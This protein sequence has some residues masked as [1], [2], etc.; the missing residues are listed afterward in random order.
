ME[1]PAPLWNATEPTPPNRS[2][3]KAAPAATGCRT[4]SRRDPSRQAALPGA[5]LCRP[6]A[7]PGDQRCT[8]G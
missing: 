7:T 3:P 6:P 4:G 2:H 5:H 8:S 1:R